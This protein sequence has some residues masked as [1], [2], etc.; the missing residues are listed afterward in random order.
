MQVKENT[1]IILFLGSNLN[2]MVD[3]SQKKTN[4]IIN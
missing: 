3:N 4:L 2:T 1:L